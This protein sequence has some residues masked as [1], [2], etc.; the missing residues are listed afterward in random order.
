M[1]SSILFSA[2]LLLSV[3]PSGFEEPV[4]DTLDAVII[5]A[6]KGLTV[7][8]KDTLVIGNS[9]SISEVLMRSSGFHVGDNGG[10]AGL[11][12]LSLRGL[13]SAHTAVYIDGLRVGNVQSG[14]NDLGMIGIDNLGSVVID[15]AQNSVSFNTAKPVFGVFPVS[16]V[17]RLSGGSF[18][19]WLPSARIDARLSEKIV[20][21]ANASGVLSKGD[22]TY[23]D[24]LVRENNDVSQVRA[25]LDLWGVMSGGDY[26][27]KAYYNN[28]DR[29][30]PGSTDWPSDDR[31]KDRNAFVQSTVR[32]NFSPL[33]TLRLSA[34]ASYDDIFY[35]S[36][37]GDSNYA[38]TEFQINSVHDFR[39]NRCW[40]VSLAADIQW[41]GLK[42]S[43]Y[44]ATRLTTFSALAT[45]YRAGRFS[46][47][48]A[49][50]Y[51]GAFDT[52][53]LSRHSFSP[54]ANLRL[55]VLDGLDIIAFA[56]R[57]YRIPTFNELYYVGYGNPDLKPEDA[58][59]SDIGVDFNRS[60]GSEWTIK[61]NLDGFYNFLKDKI[62]SAP[63]L[64]DPNIWLPYNI[65]K[66][67]SA[68]FNISAGFVHKGE[69]NYSLNAEYTFQ[70][71]IDITPDSYTYGQQIP[72]I[73]RHVVALCGGVSWK[74]W[75][76]EPTWQMRAGRTD[77]SGELPDWNTM[78]LTLSKTFNIKN[79]GRM[80][81][82]AAA[83][84]IADCRYETVSGYPMPGRNFILGVEF[85]F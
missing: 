32:K 55:N 37:W 77:A 54:S 50:E 73:A 61:A 34:K 56:R 76:L 46:F 85:K 58:W 53:A 31:Q 65:G 48:A 60:V 47:D 74:G 11:K 70:S 59:L 30:T 25:G 12:S 15:Y 1:L 4:I 6:D 21:S 33:Y 69:W 44:S 19:T 23:G 22:F 27:V 24:G 14:Q 52:G 29:G 79:A 13:G 42:S 64:E 28:V 39:I 80:T 75:M 62:T 8:R 67:R 35:S 45:S 72:Y 41:D 68:G 2:G 36:S 43:N 71:A 82:T 26:H 10:F 5:S 17:A 63:T 20:L 7:S 49:L 18:G 83:R 40:N 57:A 66:V 9:F 38:Q 3:L 51:S 81:L 78:D 84:N 16:G